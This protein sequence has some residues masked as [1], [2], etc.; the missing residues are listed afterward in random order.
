[1]PT[2]WWGPLNQTRYQQELASYDAGAATLHGVPGLLARPWDASIRNTGVLDTRAGMDAWFLWGLPLLLAVRGTGA[3]GPALFA[4][5]WYALWHL[6]PHQVRYLLP[7]WP[8][9]AIATAAAARALTRSSGFG[10]GLGWVLA[11]ILVWHLPNALRLQREAGDPV[12]VVFGAEPPQVYLARGMPG[13]EPGL[14]TREWLRQQPGPDRVLVAN[15]YGLN[16]FWGAE[17]IV[18]SFFDTPMLERFARESRDAAGIAR[19]FRQAGIGWV[20]CES[21][22]NML[23]QA[24]YHIYNLDAGAAAR[25]RDYWSRAARLA[26]SADGR[27][28]VYRLSRPGPPAPVSIVPGLDEQA[29]AAL[30]DAQGVGEARGQT[31]AELAAAEARYRAVA[32]RT[33]LPAAW[34][35]VGLLCLRADRRREAREAFRRAARLGR[36]TAAVRNGLGIL[37]AREGRIG[38]AVAAFREALALDAGYANARCNLALCYKALGRP[39]DGLA[40]LTEGLRRDPGATDLRQAWGMLTGRVPK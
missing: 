28:A 32:E 14:R 22:N 25:W 37:D 15:Q 16:L 29:L 19:R 2:L 9:A 34:E 31:A 10:R 5:G 27:L 30:D 6:I 21:E 8:A 24:S 12:R 13:H 23:M 33:D 7:V 35:R 18:Q 20:V 38:P 36:L 3:G 1:M 4:L 17:A 40:V 26:F 11:G 39:A